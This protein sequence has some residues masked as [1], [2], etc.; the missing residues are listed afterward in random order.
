[1]LIRKDTPAVLDPE[2]GFSASS[3][4]ENMIDDLARPFLEL[5]QKLEVAC[6]EP[7]GS[8]EWG[9]V[10]DANVY[11]WRFVAN[12]LPGQVDKDVCA[13]LGETLRTI[14][15]FMHMACR[16]LR[17]ERDEELT[18]RVI[19]LNLNMCAQILD[20]RRTLLGLQDA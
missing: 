10:L 13:E 9:A 1:M 16:K 6:A 19:E 15:D 12:Y 8:E 17:S 18:G 5:A 11:I 14:G 20:L 4:A 7:E 3:D 2:S